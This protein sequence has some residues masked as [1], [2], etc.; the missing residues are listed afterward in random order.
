MLST[1]ILMELFFNNY[2][3]APQDLIYEQPLLESLWDS[4]S[5][6]SLIFKHVFETIH[7]LPITSTIHNTHLQLCYFMVLDIS[8]ACQNNL[9]TLPFPL[10]ISP[11]FT[12]IHH[13][14]PQPSPNTNTSHMSPNYS[15]P[16]TRN[17]VASVIL[18]TQ[19]DRTRHQTILLFF[20][21]RFAYIQTL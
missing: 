19:L 4:T 10:D 5:K 17:P 3:G 14:T 9:K 1:V 20:H 16:N 15:F 12:F 11:A 18:Q 6:G 13:Q 8:H 2:I 21:K 7:C